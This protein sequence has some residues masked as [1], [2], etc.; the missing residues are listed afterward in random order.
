MMHRILDEFFIFGGPGRVIFASAAVN[1]HPQVVLDGLAGY[2]LPASSPVQLTPEVR[3]LVM[4]G[5]LARLHDIDIDARKASLANDGISKQR[6][7]HGMRE[8][9]SSVRRRDAA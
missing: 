8:P 6:A 7:E 4:G 5:N 1:P 9:F 3:A 2:E